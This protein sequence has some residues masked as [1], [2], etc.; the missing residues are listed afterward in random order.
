MAFV[1]ANARE[2]VHAFVR[3]VEGMQRRSHGTWPAD[4]P[5][6]RT[7][8]NCALVKGMSG[9]PY[10]DLRILSRAVRNAWPPRAGRL[11]PW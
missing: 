7:A 11:P 4:I 6:A 9:L 10:R 2:S 8:A 1:L 3:E 5:L